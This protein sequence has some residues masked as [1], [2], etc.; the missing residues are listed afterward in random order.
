[1]RR[2]PGVLAALVLAPVAAGGA[3][4]ALLTVASGGL[5]CPLALVEGTLVDAS[6]TLAVESDYGDNTVVTVHWPLGYGVSHDAG[7]LVLTRLFSPVA[8]EGDHVAMGGSSGDDGSFT[9]CGPIAVRPA[10]ASPTP[11]GTPPP[12]L[13]VEE[14]RV[15]RAPPGWRFMPRSQSTTP[16]RGPGPG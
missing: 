13:E 16:R 12:T 7:T 5:G 8:R 4:L 9:A 14:A 1:V 11:S 3:A 15:L 2:T 10:G 6:G